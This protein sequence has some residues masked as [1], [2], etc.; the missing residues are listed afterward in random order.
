[1]YFLASICLLNFLT[2]RGID[3]EKI[4][5]IKVIERHAKIATK[6][7]VD[8]AYVQCVKDAEKKY[9]DT[10]WSE[11]TIVDEAWLAQCV[12]LESSICVAENHLMKTFDEELEGLDKEIRAKGKKIDFLSCEAGKIGNPNCKPECE[13]LSSEGSSASTVTTTVL[14]ALSALAFL[15]K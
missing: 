4:P 6:V 11:D 7:I 2:V 8:P 15:S 3:E 12:V 13:K 5:A 1:M 14:F 9:K 10:K